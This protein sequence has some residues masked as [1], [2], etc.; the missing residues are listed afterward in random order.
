MTEAINS[1]N[2]AASSLFLGHNGEWWDFWLIVS[3][4]FAAVAA[5]AIGVTTTGSIVSH[6]REA[7]ASELELNRYKAEA[8]KELAEANS[9]AAKAN[10]SAAK[11]NNETARLQADN[12]ALQTVLLP[13]H[14]GLIGIDQ[15]PPA[16]KWF[17]GFERWAG[18]KVLIQVIPGD[19]EAQN[20]AN[21]IAIV[22]SK[23]G[24]L[25]EMIDERRT[26]H[27]L[28][29]SEGL[30][31]FSPSSYKAWDPKDE[32]RQQFAKLSMAAIALG[33][34]LTAA[35]LGIGSS[36]VSGAHGLSLVVDFPP[37]SDGDATNP[38]RNFKPPLEVGSR[39]VGLTMQWIRQGRPDAVGNLPQ[40]TAPTNKI[41]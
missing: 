9:E 18:I 36:P 39:P 8:A 5:T 30:S 40:P 7:V 31:V 34:A 2:A 12:L 15:P 24:W 37:G 19:A 35:G 17:V 27:S 20:L 4:V 21:E 29:L 10:E 28:H 26:G 22:L 14:V 41:K 25:P 6:R 3:V 1:A 16:I 33:N 32:A 38:Y 23:K 13:R 11:L